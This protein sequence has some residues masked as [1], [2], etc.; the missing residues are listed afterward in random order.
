MQ[1]F[2]IG[3]V[4]DFMGKRK[5]FAPISLLLVIGAIVSLFVPGPKL[6]TDFKGGTEL[7]VEFKQKVDVDNVRS[8]VTAAGFSRPD[9]VKADV[10]ESENRFLIR[11]QE[12][13]EISPE[14]QQKFNDLVCFGDNLPADRCPEEKQSSEVKYSPGG[15]KIS[16]RFNSKPDLDAVRQAVAQVDGL[17]VRGGDTAVTIQN[18]RQNRVE[19]LLT[20]RGDQLL[21]ALQKGL[22][23]D[24]APD[25]PLSQEWIGPKAGAQLRD[26]AIKSI[27]I[28]L[29]FIMVYIAFRFDLRFAPGAVAALIHDALLTLLVLVLAQRELNLATVA[30]I[31]TI[32]GYSVNDTVVVY[33]RVR[34]NLGRMRG[35]SMIKIINTSLSEM[36]SRTVLTSC[37]TIFS[38]M[39]FFLRGTGTL[40]DFAFTLI[41]GLILGTYS[42]IYV[43]LPL[44]EFLDRKVFSKA[45][46]PKRRSVRA[47]KGRGEAVV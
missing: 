25:K 32:V 11:V 43:A 28:A 14:Q 39:F 15:D 8:V 47:D 13:S 17:E 45:A 29:V 20:S 24:V 18:E 9:V 19:V 10:G 42:S 34:E 37:T 3:K 33:D 41:I 1:L 5:A 38:L 31:L 12:V 7:R 22:G 40:K 26:A 23:A 36:L 46:K 27:L 4:Y 30:A 35:S 44:T 16:I 21:G 2:P 6:G